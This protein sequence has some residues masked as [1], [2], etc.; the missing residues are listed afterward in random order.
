MSQLLL[1][2][3]KKKW[4]GEYLDHPE[5]PENIKIRFNPDT[6]PGPEPQ[7]SQYRFVDYSGIKANTTT[8]DEELQREMQEVARRM[9]EER[10]LDMYGYKPL[11]PD[12]LDE[13]GPMKTYP[14]TIKFK[15]F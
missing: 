9:Q 11:Y 14:W 15:W 2:A 5:A 6:M 7:A 10:I 13:P 8:A 3:P 4:V 1:P 12:D